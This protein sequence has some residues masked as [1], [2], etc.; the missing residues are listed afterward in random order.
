VWIQGI[1]QGSAE[2]KE[3]IVIL[4]IFIELIVRLT[5]FVIRNFRVFF[6]L[7]IGTGFG[8]ALGI[9]M[10]RFGNVDI[11]MILLAVVIS[12]VVIAPKIVDYINRLIP[13]R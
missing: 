1:A 5:R 3:V 9:S 11:W 12:A 2:G 13:R 8:L 4:E 10:S 7:F 6:A